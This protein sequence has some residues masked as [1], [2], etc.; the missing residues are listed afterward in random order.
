MQNNG[1]RNVH[2]S[3][4]SFDYGVVGNILPAFFIYVSLYIILVDVVVIIILGNI[5]CKK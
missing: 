1:N 3:N 4:T 5:I 2:Y